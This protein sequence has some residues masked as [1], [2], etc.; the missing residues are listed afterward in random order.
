M[1]NWHAESTRIE[2]FSFADG[3]VLSAMNLYNHFFTSERDDVIFGLEGDNVIAAK[4]GNDTITLASGNHI[5][6]AGYGRDNIT[7]ASGDDV[8]YTG[9]GADT[10]YSGA[11]NDTINTL[12]DGNHVTGGAGDDILNGGTGSDHYHFGLGSGHDWVLDTGGSDA[13]Y[14]DD[15]ETPAAIQIVR[16]GDDVIVTLE[17]DSTIFI[18]DWAQPDNRVEFIHFSDGTI[19]SV[20]SLLVL[21][22]EDYDLNLL[23]D[24]PLT[25]I[26]ELSGVTEG[27]VFTVEQSSSNGVFTLN[28]DGSWNYQPTENY[29]GSDTVVVNVTNST[30]G[31]ASS[32]I[33]LTIAPVN[34]APVVE[35][36]E[37]PYQILGTLIQEGDLSASDVDGDSLTYAVDT[38]PEHGVL[39]INDAGRWAYTAED[40]YCGA[41]TAVIA[42]ADGNGGTAITTLDFSV[43][44]YSGGDLTIA[45]DGPTGLLL[46]GISKNQLHLTRQGDDLNVAVADQGTVTLKD[47]FTAAENGIDWLQTT[48][49]PV[50]LAKDAI[51]EGGSS[52]WPIEWFSGQ[53]NVND[54]M[55]GTWRFDLMYGRGGNDILFG[56]AGTDFLKGSGGD[57]TLIGG[58]GR[59]TLRG[60]KGSDT[61][62]GDSGWDFLNG[63]SGD[64]ALIGGEGNDLLL[65]GSGNDRLWGDHGNDFLSG[66]TDNDT[67]TF[68]PGDGSDT[69]YDKSG[70]DAIT[71]AADVVK[72]EIAFLKTGTTMKID[73]GVDDQ[74]TMN[75]YSD[76][77]SGNRI[78]TITLADGSYLTDAD[79]NQLIQEMSAYAIVEGIGLDSLDN[80]RQDEQLMTMIADSWHAA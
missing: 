74:I 20:E 55:S 8:I 68:S 63:N 40:G 28:S 62:F 29:H 35:S 57:D 66:G 3:S 42:V 36:N 72:E 39:D 47:Y 77:T 45:G 70:T 54:L 34:D 49:G 32:T 48:D 27:I 9:E 13:L 59:D 76:S 61:L 79:I 21:Q 33:N 64:D 4:G 24:Q 17:D 15:S 10:V 80:V 65:G 30:G 69:L 12:G 14:L 22:V 2:V 43:N 60:G 51:Q 67:Y 31:T 5:V 18:K 52:W 23:E 78:E 7:T 53:D 58:T 6:D 50:F 26:I 11:G 46:D 75:R 16:V 41:D 37:E 19:F 1:T 71:F 25:G 56:G 44:T 73:Y 38:L